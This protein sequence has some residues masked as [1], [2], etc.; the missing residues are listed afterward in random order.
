MQELLKIYNLPL[1][2]SLL[3]SFQLL[4]CLGAKLIEMHRKRPIG[5]HS[6]Q[7]FIHS[8]VLNEQSTGI[9]CKE[10]LGKEYSS[11][12][13]RILKKLVAIKDNCY[14]QNTRKEHLNHKINHLTQE[15]LADIFRSQ[16]VRLQEILT[17]L[18]VPNAWSCF[19]RTDL[20]SPK[21]KT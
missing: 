2:V 1:L 18:R 17:H 19:L 13:Y 10:Y 15:G 11:I 20:F 21:Q 16:E 8:M 5:E 12:K 6:D 9:L 14:N 7:R 3:L 4:T